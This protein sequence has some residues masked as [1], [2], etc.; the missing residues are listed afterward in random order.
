MCG[1]PYYQQMLH[2]VCKHLVAGL[3]KTPGM[4]YPLPPPW[5]YSAF[6]NLPPF[7]QFDLPACRDHNTDLVQCDNQI[8]VQQLPAPVVADNADVPP[9]ICDFISDIT[10]NLAPEERND[11]LE[12]Q[13]PEIVK[14]LREFL[15][16]AEG[17]PIQEQHFSRYL[18]RID[19][20]QLL[21][22]YLIEWQT[23]RSRRRRVPHT[24][25]QLLGSQY[26]R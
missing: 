5:N 23:E 26:D 11:Q 8:P 21:E 9:D 14:L 17:N 13:T 15:V 16:S 3:E 19:R 20:Q 4:E 12:L 1:C 10:N 2:K 25:R 24:R 7:L 6:S 22:K 18:E